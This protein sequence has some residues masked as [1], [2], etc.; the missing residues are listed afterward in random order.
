MPKPCVW[1]RGAWPIGVKHNGSAGKSLLNFGGR[2]GRISERSEGFNR[3]DWGES[4]ANA[5]RIM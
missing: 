3:I 4:L 2:M 5:A 1:T